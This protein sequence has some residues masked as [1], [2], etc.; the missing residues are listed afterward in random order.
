MFHT[1]IGK[2]SILETIGET[3]LIR[4]QEL[5]KELNT[6]IWGKLEAANPGHS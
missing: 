4:L 6:N 2:N 3:P 5:S 1:V